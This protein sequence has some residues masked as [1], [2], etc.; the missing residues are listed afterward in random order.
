MAAAVAGARTLRVAG[1][2]HSFSAAAVTD[3]TQLRLDRLDRVLD[4]DPASGL[5]RVEAG[6]TL[7]RLNR[8]LLARGLALPNLGDV[9]VQTLAGALATGTHGTGGGSRTCR[10]PWRGWSS[11]SPTAAS[12]S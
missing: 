9:D 12:A 8:E 4:A 6:I 11:S 5:V 7:H 3:G 1:A 2:G 10:R